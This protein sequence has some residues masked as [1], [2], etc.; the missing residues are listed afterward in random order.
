MSRP[1]DSSVAQAFWEARVRAPWSFEGNCII[2]RAV[3]IDYY[4]GFSVATDVHTIPEKVTTSPE[5]VQIPAESK[6][7]RCPKCTGSILAGKWCN[8]PLCP[9]RK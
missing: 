4:R 5:R 3:E 2:D 8:G 1:S 6:R 9:L 7:V